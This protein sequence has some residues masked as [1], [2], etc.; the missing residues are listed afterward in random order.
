MILRVAARRLGNCLIS[1]PRSVRGDRTARRRVAVRAVLAGGVAGRP[2]QAD[3]P[4]LLHRFVVASREYMEFLRRSGLHR[5]T[6]APAV[7][8][9][10]RRPHLAGPEDHRH[11]H[12]RSGARRCEC[13]DDR[14]RHGP[15][16]VHE[17]VE[18]APDVRR[19][20]RVAVLHGARQ[21][22][23]LGYRSQLMTLQHLCGN[24]AICRSSAAR[25]MNPRRGPG[26]PATSRISGRAAPSRRPGASATPRTPTS[27]SAGARR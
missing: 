19:P 3:P 16:A 17:H 5:R 10:D 4:R 15:G 18:H 21:S 26:Q 2:E 1:S 22:W 11:V 20:A 27:S 12:A 14:H 8:P 13:R 6:D 24:F 25:K 23:D 9:E 7:Q